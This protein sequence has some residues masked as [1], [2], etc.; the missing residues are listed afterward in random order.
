MPG[1]SEALPD[2]MASP[3]PQLMLLSELLREAGVPESEQPCLPLGALGHQLVGRERTDFVRHLA[4]LGVTKLGHRMRLT[5]ALD[6]AVRSGRVPALVDVQ[7]LGMLPLPKGSGAKADVS[8]LISWYSSKELRASA[9]RSQSACQSAMAYMTQAL[10]HTL[11][12][13]PPRSPPTLPRAPSGG[14]KLLLFI[15][16]HCTGES[17]LTK[18]RRCLRSVSAQMG[19]GSGGSGDDWPLDGVLVSWSA[20][21]ASLRSATRSTFDELLHVPNGLCAAF[22]RPGT[23]TQMQHL[24][25]L[26]PEAQRLAGADGATDGATGEPRELWV[27]FSDDDDILHPARCSAYR[28]AIAAAPAHAQA[29]SAAWVARPI[30]VEDAVDSAA[31]VDRLVEAGRVVRTPKL[32]SEKEGGGGSWD[33]YWNAALRVATLQTFFDSACPHSGRASKYADMA[34]YYYLKF[35]VPTM[36]FEPHAAHEFAGCWMHYYDKPLRHTDAAA[37]GAAS[38][39][40]SVVDG[41]MKRAAQMRQTLEATRQAAEIALGQTNAPDTAERAHEL[42]GLLDALRGFLEREDAL[43]STEDTSTPLVALAAQI[44]SVL[45]LLCAGFVGAPNMPSDAVLVEVATST[46]TDSLIALGHAPAVVAAVC[47]PHLDQVLQ[48]CTSMFGLP[49]RQA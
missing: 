47:L 44:R 26:L 10:V 42:R 46:V 39:G 11:A 18:L 23:W 3:T 31:D 16:C 24:A 30:G 20:S 14:A 7:S 41:D 49:F 48:L 4:V 8:Q 38:S 17:R 25:S 22:E 21:D 33:E 1:L 6:A 34:L 5:N 2:Q 40:A 35:A 45:E 29:V 27:M 9:Q 12:P 43:Q 36:R 32:G 15:A 19:G 37:S 13:D 28:A